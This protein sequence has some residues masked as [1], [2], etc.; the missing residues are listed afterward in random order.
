MRCKVGA[1]IVVF[2][3]F[4]AGCA[5]KTAT[6]NDVLVTLP[7]ENLSLKERRLV[8]RFQEYWHYRLN[9]DLKKTYEYELPYQRFL[10]SYKEYKGL[11]D[12]YGKRARVELV[13]ISFL[14]PDVAVIKRKIVTRKR[15][16]EGK[17]KW[18]RVNGEWYHKFFQN[19]L[20]PKNKEEEEFQ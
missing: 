10:L 9:G 15:T 5:P 2:L 18:L 14:H 20:P 17:D 7:K 13:S 19:I 16:F 12:G 8:R 3:A 1:T 4:F 11:L 6:Y